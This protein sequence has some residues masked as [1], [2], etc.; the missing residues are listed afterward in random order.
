MSF[1]E[2]YEQWKVIRMLRELF[3]EAQA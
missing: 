1:C 3:L 2:N